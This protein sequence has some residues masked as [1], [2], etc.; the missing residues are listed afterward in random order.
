MPEI[1]TNWV[2]VVGPPPKYGSFVKIDWQNMK[3]RKQPSLLERYYR[4]P[5][6][7]NWMASEFHSNFCFLLGW[8]HLKMV[9]CGDQQIDRPLSIANTASVHVCLFKSLVG[10]HDLPN[11]RMYTAIW[12]SVRAV[13]YSAPYDDYIPFY[14]MYFALLVYFKNTRKCPCNTKIWFYP[15]APPSISLSLRIVCTW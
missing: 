10:V 13:E 2:T 8:Q 12:T 1:E 7:R 6:R 4:N 14:H 5:N 3:P 11:T 9:K 15:S